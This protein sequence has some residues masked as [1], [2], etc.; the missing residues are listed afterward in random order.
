[1][2]VAPQRRRSMQALRPTTTARQ[3]AEETLNARI[4]SHIAEVRAVGAQDGRVVTASV[5]VGAD[6][7]L[8]DVRRQLLADGLPRFAGLA[9]WRAVRCAVLAS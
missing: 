4:F 3:T 7:S 1:M 5:L 9:V 2:Q 6:G 8:S